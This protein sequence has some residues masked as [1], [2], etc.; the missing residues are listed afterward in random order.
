MAVQEIF[1]SQQAGDSKVE[2]IKIYD[3]SSAR[4]AFEDMDDAAMRHL[5]NALKLESNYEIGALPKLGD[6]NNEAESFLWDELCEQARE[7][8]NL[9]SFFVVTESHGGRSQSR[10][11]SPDWP[12][13]ESYAK[14]LIG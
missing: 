10:Y 5:W 6:P 7:D 9:L 2:V 1:F 13:A 14:G 4:E 11:V 12:S 3:R 8:G